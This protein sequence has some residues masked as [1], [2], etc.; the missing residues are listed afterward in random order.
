MTDE[1]QNRGQGGKIHSGCVFL[2]SAVFKIGYIKNYVNLSMYGRHT[3][4]CQNGSFYLFVDL[5]SESWNQLH[6][7]IFESS[8][9]ILERGVVE[10]I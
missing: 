9:A 5:V 4:N 2:R 1:Y 8:E 10:S 3:K 7:W 6:S